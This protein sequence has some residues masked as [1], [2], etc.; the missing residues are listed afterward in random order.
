MTDEEVQ[1]H[2]EH[3]CDVYPVAPEQE[4]IGVIAQIRGHAAESMAFVDGHPEY[5]GRWFFVNELS[6]SCKIPD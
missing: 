6:T 3:M 4:H 2:A 5:P 1:R